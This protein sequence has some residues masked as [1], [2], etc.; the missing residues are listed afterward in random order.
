MENKK[1]NGKKIAL[2]VTCSVLAL[3]LMALLTVLILGKSLLNRIN[4]YD[5]NS[6]TLS[7]AQLESILNETDSLE[8]DYTGTIMNSDDV[9]MP[10]NPADIVESDNV[11][12]ILLVGQDRRAGQVRQRSDAMILC[13]I[14]KEN[15]TLVM[16]SFLR[17]TWVTIPNRYDE[18]LNVPYAIRGGGFEL[19]NETLQYNFGVSADY[20]VEVDFAGFKEV[21]NK[22]DGVDVELTSAEAKYLNKHY[23]WKLKE[24]V[25][26]MTG[27][28][29]LAFSRIRALDSDFGRTYRQRTVLTALFNKVKGMS[30]VKIY[31]VVNEILPSITTDMTNKEILSLVRELAP[32][33]PDLKLTAQ[34]I[35]INNGFSFARIDGK[36]VLYMSP[37]NLEKN[38]QFLKDT[39][40]LDVPKTPAE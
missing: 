36:S 11:I 2:I 15:K 9:D 10:D 28:Q 39:L 21:I 27:S 25:N 30:I 22:V 37:E 26:H 38:R 17:D 5:P 32:L 40:G 14:N 12:N 23:G 33:M 16:T 35:P 24:G 13:T 1:K 4:R 6:G 20:N 34:R 29:A 7:S 18:R 3:I 31:Q 19:L 8:S